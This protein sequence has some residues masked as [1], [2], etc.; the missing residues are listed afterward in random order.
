MQHYT[1]HADTPYGL[2]LDETILPEYLNNIGFESHA[3]GKWHLGHHTKEYTPTFR[4]FSSH[5]GYWLGKEDYYDH[6]DDNGKPESV[7]SRSKYLHMGSRKNTSRVITRLVRRQLI[8]ISKTLKSRSKSPHLYNRRR[9]SS[10]FTRLASWKLFSI[11][12]TL[13][14]RSK[15]LQ[16]FH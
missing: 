4:G 2:P 7:N 5:C 10:V 15:N 8:S 13:N 11:S 12:K 16:V 14:S 6:S 9:T 1:I 3:V